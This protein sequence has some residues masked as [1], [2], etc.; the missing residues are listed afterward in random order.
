MNEQFIIKEETAYTL[1][2]EDT[3]AFLKLNVELEKL[4]FKKV[5]RSRNISLC[6]AENELTLICQDSNTYTH[7]ISDVHYTKLREKYPNIET[8]YLMLETGPVIPLTFKISN[9]TYTFGEYYPNKN[10]VVIC[11]CL[12]GYSNPDTFKFVLE[13]LQENYERLKWKEVKVDRIQELCEIFQE[14]NNKIVQDNLKKIESYNQ[15]IKRQIEWIKDTQ[16]NIFLINLQNIGL[17]E[18]IKIIN[19]KSTIKKVI[20]SKLFTIDEDIRNSLRDMEITQGD[21]KDKIKLVEPKVKENIS[22][23]IYNAK[24]FKERI[25]DLSELS[26]VKDLRFTKNGEIKFEIR[27]VKIKYGSK[28]YSMGNFTAIITPLNIYFEGERYLLI[29][30]Q[31]YYHP[32]I[33]DKRC[34][35]GT[36][37]KKMEELRMKMQFSELAI[38]IKQFLNTY[39]PN[40]RYMDLSFF[41]GAKRNGE[42]LNNGVYGKDVEY[43]Q[44]KR[45]E[46]KEIN[47]Y[48][49]E[50]FKDLEQ[51]YN[52]PEPNLQSN[53]EELNRIFRENGNN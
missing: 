6:L 21:L 42:S 38:L 51:R 30:G 48:V 9:T 35:L 26:F 27:D 15:D 36:F 45:E 37:R 28:V 8:Q 5:L 17:L 50:E 10:M 39:T 41:T 49:E 22:S 31:K 1:F 14:N 24:T 53:V 33:Y 40:D 11:L 34:C 12:D 32:H 7:K 44:G 29:D 19:P 43:I 4:G 52:E 2:R 46:D 47:F 20:E 25:K 13:V 3:K 18:S 16:Q 23:N